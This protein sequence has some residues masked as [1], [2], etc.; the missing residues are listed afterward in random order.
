MASC[1]TMRSSFCLMPCAHTNSQKELK[2]SVS[3]QKSN[4]PQFCV[5][6]PKPTKRTSENLPPLNP[7]PNAPCREYTINIIQLIYIINIYIYIYVHVH[8]FPVECGHF[9]PFCPG[10]FSILHFAQTTSG[11]T[12]PIA[13]LG[14]VQLHLGKLPHF[15]QRFPLLFFFTKFRSYVP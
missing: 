12:A 9:S 14:T 2:I 6:Y 3:F 13:R 5:R 15:P 1:E 11:N 4:G 7:I 8:T 10:L